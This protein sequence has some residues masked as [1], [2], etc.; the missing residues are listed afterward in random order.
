M[1][2]SNM[3]L[4]YHNNLKNVSWLEICQIFE[5]VGWGERTPKEIE[6]TFKESSHIRIVQDNSKVVAFGR[7]VDDGRHYALIVDLV[8]EPEYQGKGIGKK[9]LESYVMS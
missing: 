7:T 5:N 9:Y 4:I 6:K 1:Y 8:I 3:S 2:T